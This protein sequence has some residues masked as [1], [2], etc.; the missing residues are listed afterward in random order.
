MTNE[1]LE[2]LCAA[3][4]AGEANYDAAARTAIQMIGYAFSHSDISLDDA[5]GPK[6]IC[7]GL[8]IGRNYINFVRPMFDKYPTIQYALRCVEIAMSYQYAESVVFS[9]PFNRGKQGQQTFTYAF[10][11]SDTG[12]VKIGRTTDLET[13]YV[14]LC[15]GC[16]TRLDVVGI[17]EADV[18][19]EMHKKF[20]HLRRKGEWFTDKDSEITQFISN[21]PCFTRKHIFNSSVEGIRK[22]VDGGW[23]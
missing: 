8:S 16:G 1:E 11:N 23:R 2:K 14:T 4:Q 5:D 21:S 19:K 13:R 15:N 17:C 18:E 22:L 12:L 10:K 9:S 6:R 3:I 7:E 20:M